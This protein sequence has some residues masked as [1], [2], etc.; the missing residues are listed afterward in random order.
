VH[1]CPW[2]ETLPSITP[3]KCAPA[4]TIYNHYI[5]REKQYCKSSAS[6]YDLYE[7]AVKMHTDFITAI[8]N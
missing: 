8:K 5:F 7:Q 3:R 2:T 1:I 4:A 6:T